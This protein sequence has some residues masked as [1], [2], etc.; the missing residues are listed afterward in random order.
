MRAPKQSGSS[1]TQRPEDYYPRT[2]L[3]S[4]SNSI[5]GRC[6]NCRYFTARRVDLSSSFNLRSTHRDTA[7]RWGGVFAAHEWNQK[8][9]HLPV[10]VAHGNTSSPLNKSLRIAVRRRRR[11]AIRRQRT[12]ARASI[13]LDL[14]RAAGAP[15]HR[16]VGTTP[17]RDRDSRYATQA[18]A[19]SATR[20]SVT[21]RGRTTLCLVVQPKT[22][23]ARALLRRALVVPATHITGRNVPLADARYRATVQWHCRRY[24][25]S[26]PA[27]PQ[28]LSISST[29]AIALDI[30]K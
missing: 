6:A 14:S 16:P 4:V 1:I 3:C 29:Y 17:V 7:S 21:G 30:C 19:I 22:E 27:T 15:P 26:G 9:L 24:S 28:C 8:T 5:A 2:V 10:G 13:E 18:A 23:R 11:R 20:R 25:G 12:H